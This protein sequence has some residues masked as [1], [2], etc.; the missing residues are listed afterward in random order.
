VDSRPYAATLLPLEG[1]IP[2]GT[3]LVSDDDATLAHSVFT[4]WPDGSAAVVIVNGSASLAAGEVKTVRV[5]QGG[6]ATDNRPSLT[7]ADI[8]RAIQSVKVEI[9]STITATRTDFAAPDRIWWA[10]ARAICARYRVRLPHRSLEA[11]VDIH[12]YAGGQAFVEVVIENGHMDAT[13]PTWPETA[14]YT[15]ASVTVNNQALAQNVSSAGAAEGQHSGFRAWYAAAWIGGGTTLRATQLHTDLQKH[16]LLF[17]MARSGTATG[18]SALGED[19]YVPWTTARQRGVNMGGTG[20]HA[21]IGPLTLWDAR[22]LQTGDAGAANASEVSTLAVLSYNVNFRDSRSG[23]PPNFQDIGTKNQSGSNPSWPRIGNA[24]DRV[25]WEVAHHPAAGLMAFV[26]RPSPV[27]LEIAQKICVWNGTMSADAFDESGWTSGTFGR[28]Y[29]IRG[30]AWSLRSL[31]HACFLT[32]RDHPWRA[33]AVTTLANN[34]TF[35]RRWTTSSRAKL[36]VMWDAWPDWGFED[37]DGWN[38]FQVKVWQF[39]FLITE[40]HK[41]ASAKLLTGDAQTQLNGLAD[42]CALQPVRWVNEQPEGGWRYVTYHTTVG[43]DSATIDSADTWGEQMRWARGGVPSSVSGPWLDINH[44]TEPYSAAIAA[45]QAGSFWH[46]YFWASLTAA[47]ERNIPGARTAWN[48]VQQ[49]V[50]NLS[51]WMDGFASDPRWGATPRNI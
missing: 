8:S 9:T 35:L 46:S 37:A 51:P 44:A 42:W 49:N 10:N 14:S 20:D 1:Q 31:V 43:R 39:H 16:P 11:V 29:Q 18:L 6:A 17:K 34:V 2:S 4:T 22:F 32:P 5:Q 41:A 36:N 47:V 3:V 38:G 30:R 25:L 48:T 12:V 7:V 27:Y 24:D 13:A 50:T 40:L 45:P 15:A 19:R 26:A 23:V 28:F 21:S 33:P